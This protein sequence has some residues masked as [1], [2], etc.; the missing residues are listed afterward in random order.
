MKLTRFIT[1]IAAASLAL[2]P[3][4]AQAQSADR[5][6]AVVQ[7]VS[8]QEDQGSSEL[9]I[10]MAIAIVVIIGFSVLIHEGDSA[11]P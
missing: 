1:G 3:V 5:A 8:N 7:E 6:G 11:S 2:S 4:V 9:L 10:F